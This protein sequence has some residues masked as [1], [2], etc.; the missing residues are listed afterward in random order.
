MN[1][2]RKSNRKSMQLQLEKEIEP[3]ELRAMEKQADKAITAI[4][5]GIYCISLREKSFIM[6]FIGMYTS[7]ST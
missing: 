2:I 5:R 1:R 3:S 7:L 6:W 4:R